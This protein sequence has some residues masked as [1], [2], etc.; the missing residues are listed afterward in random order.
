MGRLK[1]EGVRGAAG[2]VMALITAARP[3]I[4]GPQSKTLAGP[5]EEVRRVL[6]AYTLDLYCPT[7]FE[8][9][10]RSERTAIS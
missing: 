2:G 7:T 5:G 10:E 3:S 1:P 4:F 8:P 9:N 6:D